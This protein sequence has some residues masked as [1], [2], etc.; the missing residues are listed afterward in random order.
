[1]GLLA[2][3]GA[4]VTASCSGAFLLALLAASDPASAA[5]KTISGKL[6]RPGYTVIALAATGQAGAVPSPGGSFSLRP[7]AQQVTLH[8]RAPSGTYAGPIMLADRKRV[9]REVRRAQREVKRAKGRVRQAERTRKGLKQATRQ[10]KKARRR[11]KEAGRL[12]RRTRNRATLGV[13]AGARLGPIRV[14]RGY[15][16][17]SKP[18]RK[19]W[20]DGSRLARARREIPIGAGNFG[21][22]HSRPVRGMVPG[23]LDLDGIPDALDIDDD[24]DLV[25]DNLDRPTAPRAAQAGGGFP[26]SS[27]LSLDLTNT[28]N[29]DAGSSSAQIEAALPMSGGLGAAAPVGTTMELDCAGDPTAVPP[30]PGLVYCS[31]GG[32]G[33][34]GGPM[35]GFKRFPEDFDPDG[36]GFGTMTPPPGGDLLHGAR[37][38]QIRTGDLVIKHVTASAGDESQCPPPPGGSTPSCT[39]DTATLQYVFATVPALASYRDGADPPDSATVSYPVPAGGVGTRGNGFPVAPGCK[40]V[41]VPCNPGADVFVTLAFW[42]PQRRPIPG[43]PGY[44]VPQTAWIDIGGL[45]YA[46]GVSQLSGQNPRHATC[47]Q[48]AYSIPAGETLGPPPPGLAGVTDTRDPPDQPASPSSTLTVTLNLTQCQASLGIPW[49]AGDQLNFSL[50]AQAFQA[51][52]KAQQDFAFKRR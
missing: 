52:D 8:L 25:L 21:R 24:G 16:K 28:A 47:P 38:D 31:R 20:V 44:S 22:V 34:R 45:T 50:G 7:P 19:R 32:T 39:S 23:D 13:R 43:E 14:R 33:R 30:R 27:S 49:G 5:P 1:M 29:A 2:R 15:A 48:S 41:T 17:L 46:G 4:R 18:L 51:L 35:F 6:S 11:L 40:D 12:L 42:R 37:S 36:D 10:L 26:F 9:E 3:S